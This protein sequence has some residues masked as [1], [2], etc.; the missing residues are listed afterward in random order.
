M[1]RILLLLVIAAV[2]GYATFIAARRVVQRSGKSRRHVHSQPGRR[3]AGTFL[4]ALVAVTRFRNF[5][6]GG[7]SRCHSLAVDHRW[8]A[9]L[10]W[11]R[12]IPECIFSRQLDAVSPGDEADKSV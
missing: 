6:V 11:C 12:G 7:E 3:L 9:R 2:I 10:S 4:V 8:R 5:G 1:V